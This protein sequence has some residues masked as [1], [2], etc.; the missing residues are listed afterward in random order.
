M[1]VVVASKQIDIVMTLADKT[2]SYQGPRTQQQKKIK[3]NS[4]ATLRASYLY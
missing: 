2:Q 4:E 3:P 1:R